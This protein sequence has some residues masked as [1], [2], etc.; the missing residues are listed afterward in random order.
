MISI[1]HNVYRRNPLIL[2]SIKLNLVAL[3]NANVEYQYIVW[4]DKGDMEIENDIS[5]IINSVEYIYSDINYGLKMA[6]GG[7]VGAIPHL[8]GDIIHNVGQDDIM[9]D[10]FYRDI[11]NTFNNNDDL[12]F[13]SSN[14][15]SVDE[16][17][18]FISIMIN[19]VLYHDYRN[20]FLAFVQWFGIKDNEDKVNNA[21]NYFLASG[22]VYRKELH[23]LIDIPDVKTYTGAADFEYW[24]RILFNDYKGR[25]NQLPNWY[26]RKSRYTAGN[27][28]ID[29]LINR[30]TEEKPGHQQIAIEKVKNKYSKLWEERKR[31]DKN[32]QK[33][34]FNR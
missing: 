27:E 21:H 7:W 29:G 28:I 3:H 32:L 8:K 10:V 4:N 34:N 24:A 5:S 17:L 13:Y 25:Y 19:P 2:E 9:T 15:F 14:G 12:M 30:G 31:K 1:I 26:Y 16:G 23:N 18:N 11:F 22:T 33:F 20:P 6:T